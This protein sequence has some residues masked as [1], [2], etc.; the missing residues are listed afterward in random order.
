MLLTLALLTF[1]DVIFDRGAAPC[2]PS[3]H[4]STPASS[5]TLSKLVLEFFLLLTVPGS[6]QLEPSER[7][8]FEVPTRASGY[9]TA[10]V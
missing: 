9:R 3:S 8:C 4:P 7:A 6:Q 1:T 10:D 2:A 5:A